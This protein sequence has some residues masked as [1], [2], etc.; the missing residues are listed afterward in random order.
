MIASLGMY[1]MPHLRGA[2]DRFWTAIAA[3]LDDAPDALMRGVDL[4]EI[5]QSPDLL[6]AQTCGMP[7]RTRLH[8][9]VALI[10]TPDYD[11]PD[12]P[13]GHYFSYII[14]RRV[15]R[16]DLQ[17]LAKNGVMA[18]NDTLSQSGWA[19]PLTF[20]AELGL[21]PAQIK[22][23]HS[24][25]GS[26]R[27]VLRGQAD[28]AAIDAVTLMIWAQDDIDGMMLLDIL[29]R[30]SPTP[31]LPYITALSSDP[32]PIA[33]AIRAAIKNLS[34][35]D[36]CDLRLGGLIDIPASEYLAVPSPPVA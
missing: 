21:R 6:L 19:A 12:C 30:T 34:Q 33:K 5:W 15:D 32:T 29:A 25:L 18:F 22:Q 7:Y 3:Y 31:A 17:Q 14:R 16:R 23:T 20:M 1:D 13:P 11:L 26:I 35:E 4:W 28:Y 36:R 27:A 24:H 2:T 10:G 9:K 8:S